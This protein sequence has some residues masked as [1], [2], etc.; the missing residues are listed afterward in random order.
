MKAIRKSIVLLVT[1]GFTTVLALGFTG[2]TQDNPVSGP[3]EELSEGFVQSTAG[4]VKILKV[5]SK[6]A[7]LFKYSYWGDDDDEEEDDED[8]SW[9]RWWGSH[10][11]ATRK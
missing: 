1:A 3:D 5:D 11:R 4:P 10:H 6:T 2:C 8:D 7:S 9:W